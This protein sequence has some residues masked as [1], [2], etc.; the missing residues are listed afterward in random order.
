MPHPQHKG[1]WLQVLRG[2]MGRVL[3][4]ELAVAHLQLVQKAGFEVL[5]YRHL[6]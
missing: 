5:V 4:L 6:Y 2:D 1:T 3:A